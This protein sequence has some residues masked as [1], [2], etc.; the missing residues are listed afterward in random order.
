M[1][2]AWIVAKR[3]LGSI[4]VQPIAYIFSIVIVVITGWLFASQLASTLIQPGAPVDLS[5][6]RTFAFLFV[7]AAP[8]ITMRLLS[9]EQRSGTM[10]LLMTMPVR[11]GEVVFG[12]YLAGLIFFATTMTLT[13]IYPL[14]L[15]N[16]GNPDIG[17]ILTTYLGILLY[18]S[19]LISIGLL[20][21]ALSENQMVSFIIAFGLILVLYL[22]F[23]PAQIFPDNQNVV[24]VFNELAFD[25]HLNS[26]T[27]GLIVAKDVAYYLVIT[28]G[29]LFA[30]TRVLESRRWR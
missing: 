27:R 11:D 24:T 19:G 21:S 3:E 22:A 26:F 2:N 13:L 1:R 30:A 6:M 20:A 7:F 4:F 23:I 14:V 10:E 18:G 8:A 15:F 16:Y 25:Q 28:A 5:I 12:K 9:E 17:P 29:F